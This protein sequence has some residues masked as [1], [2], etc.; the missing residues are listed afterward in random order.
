VTAAPESIA[1][2][3]EMMQKSSYDTHALAAAIDGASIYADD[4]GLRRVSLSAGRAASF[5]TISLLIRLGEENILSAD[6]RD[7]HL[8]TVVRRGYTEIPPAPSV[9][10]LAVEAAP[11]L[12]PT[13]LGWVFA[14]LSNELSTPAEAAQVVAL[15]F[16]AVALAPIR[17][18]APARLAELALPAIARRVP[19]RVAAFLLEAAAGDVLRL[20]PNDLA[21][22]RSI[23]RQFAEN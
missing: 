22:V 10:Q 13:E 15:A 19:K 7:R 16:R 23:C 17:R 6:D 4:L 21:E 20:L 18:A 5:S 3:R 2:L 12:T 11:A 1:E 9:F 14:T 8:L